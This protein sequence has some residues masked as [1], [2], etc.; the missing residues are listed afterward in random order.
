MKQELQKHLQ[1]H[2]PKNLSSNKIRTIRE[3]FSSNTPT[4]GMLKRVYGREWTINYIAGWILYLN[5]NTNVKNKLSPSQMDFIAERIYET[6]SLKIADLTIFFRNVSEG[7]YG[8]YY[9]NLSR[10]KI[11]QWLKEYF[12]ERCEMAQIYSSTNHTEFSTKIDKVHPKVFKEMFK[13]VGEEE[14][15]HR[16]EESKK[17]GEQFKQQRKMMHSEFVEKLKSNA[18]SYSVYELKNIIE[19]W[20]KRN[21]M[22]SYVEIFETELENRNVK[23]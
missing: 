21:D 8:S 22:V 18:K 6:Y 16:K 12:D 23:K 19:I 15:D 1:I 5:K 10:E 9:E 14:I 4:L 17:V 3:V 11:M 2:N 13:G 20:S 7:Y